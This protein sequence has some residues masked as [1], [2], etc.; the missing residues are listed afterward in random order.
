MKPNPKML[1]IVGLLAGCAVG[2]YFAGTRGADGTAGA[3]GAG[4]TI[5]HSA[6]AAT[7]KTHR[8]ERRDRTVRI[9]AAARPI[10]AQVS[11]Q[12]QRVLP[13]LGQTV[14]DWREFAPDTFTV[15]LAPDLI[16]PFRVDH[17]QRENGRTVLTARVAQVE[18]GSSGLDGAFLVSTANA[19]DRWEAVVMLP[20]EE[21]H[22]HVGPGQAAVEFVPVDT[23]RCG[24]EA[25]ARAS[26]AMRLP[27]L[28]APIVGPNAGGALAAAASTAVD[29]SPYTVDVLFLY[30][31]DA[32]AAKNGAAVAIDADCS[33]FVAA[34]N[35][36]LENSQISNFQW[37]YLTSMATPSYPTTTTLRDDLDQ[38]TNGSISA[39]VAQK[40]FAYG[41]DQ[42]VMLVGGTR[43][44]AAGVAWIGG[45]PNRAA[46][47]YPCL[48]VDGTPAS[49]ATS[50]IVVCHEMGHN[51]GCR[52]DRVTQNAQDG[53][54]NYWYG[55]RF[56]DNS[57]A[58]PVA[59]EGTVMS[60]AGSRIPY[61]S[62]PNITYHG[63]TLGVPLGD[64]RAACN[65]ETMADNAAR[66]AATNPPGPEP[67]ITGQ[68]QPAAVTVGQPLS[69]SVTVTGSNLTYQWF[70]DGVALS[71]ATSSVFAVGSAALVD[72]GNYTVTASNPTGSATSQP[73]TVTVSAASPSPSGSGV[74]SVALASSGGSGGGAF[75]GGF[76]L[77]LL[78]LL[79][80]SRRWTR[81]ASRL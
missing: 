56:T 32:L 81:A 53:D 5:A 29:G 69:L 10:A 59:D 77:G 26:V 15:Q 6:P 22:V 55:Y 63:Y 46:V 21:Y 43:S 36:I 52:H 70:R 38:M 75:D 17:L 23:W 64:P 51:F 76:A 65:A 37:R 20:G 27:A 39:F 78:A 72:A 40:Q 24:S 8:T 57:G 48:T 3:A 34:S 31:P 11:P 33:N 35:A 42:V 58:Y 60:Y 7:L 2:G 9:R 30:N 44:D 68:P 74:A 71:G 49:T 19:A 41:A 25:L 54:G 67:I 12:I 66:I 80:I 47:V 14:A 4:M 50:V 45:D 1:A 28:Q 62:N 13:G 79:A 16:L 61:F 73:A 18:P